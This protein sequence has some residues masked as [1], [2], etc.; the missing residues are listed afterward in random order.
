MYH[1]TST[2]V[3]EKRHKLACTD[4][5]LLN[6]KTRN[7]KFIDTFEILAEATVDKILQE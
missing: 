4:L 1:C 7:I 6:P 3:Y 5:Q 2:I